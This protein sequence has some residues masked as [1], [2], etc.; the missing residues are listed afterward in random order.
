MKYTVDLDAIIDISL[1]VDKSDTV[2]TPDLRAFLEAK[3]ISMLW[4]MP[5]EELLKRIVINLNSFE[6][7]QYQEGDLL[8][9]GK[10]VC[11]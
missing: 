7:K 6:L 1:I 5:K 11:E 10:E 3:A 4:K 9:E 8:E 2:E